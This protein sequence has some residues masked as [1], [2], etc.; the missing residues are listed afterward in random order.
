MTTRRRITQL[1][2]ESPLSVRE[3]SAELGLSERE[4]LDHLQHVARSV[5]SSGRLNVKPA[6]CLQC[7]FVFR[8]RTRLSKP[9]RCPLCRSQRIQAPEFSIFG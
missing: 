3:I 8:K 5:A 2:Q 7:G 9:S 6:Q 1:L 4:V